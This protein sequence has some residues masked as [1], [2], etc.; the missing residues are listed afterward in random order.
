MINEPDD[1]SLAAHSAI[2]KTSKR[3]LRRTSFVAIVLLVL[4][5]GI[6]MAVNLYV[7][8]PAHHK[9][10]HPS[11]FFGGSFQS[12]GWAV[13]HGA[14]ILAI[15]AALGLL[16]AVFVVE[17]G[18]R[19]TKQARRSVTTWAIL[20]GL[21]VIGAGFNGASFLDFN[22][23]VSSLL[24]ALL[25]FGAIVCYGAILLLASSTVDD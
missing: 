21:F 18:Y 5:A 2:T 7:V 14:I 6:G 11:N 13:S 17:V 3:D 24:M 20:A 19:A 12:V 9:G 8:V 25:T 1:P 16:L 4:Q 22:K 10:A 15:R 23:A